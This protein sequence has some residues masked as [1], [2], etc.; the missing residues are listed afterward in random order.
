MEMLNNLEV[1]VINIGNA[2]L[3]GVAKEQVYSDLAPNSRILI[4]KA[5]L[6]PAHLAFG[7]MRDFPTP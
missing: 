5:S 7:R 3:E 4:Y 1:W 6:G 2:Y